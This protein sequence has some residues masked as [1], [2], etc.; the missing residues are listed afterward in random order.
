MK[1]EKIIS[2]LLAAALSALLLVFLS[3]C[4]L[5]NAP[6]E[7][8]DDGVCVT[9]IDVGQGD[10][11]F[12]QLP[13]S[14]CMLIDTGIRDE[15]DTVID[16]IEARGYEKIDYLVGTHP[17]ADHIGAMRDVI[18]AFEIGKIYMPKVSAD[19]ATFEKTLKLIDEKG[20]G[21]TTAKA[22]VN[23]LNEENLNIDILA[24]NSSEYEELNNYSAV[25]KL[26]Y[27]DTKFLFMG[28]AQKESESEITADV[29]ADF[30]K[31][32][33]HGSKTS[34]SEEFVRRVGAKYAAVSVAEENDYNLPVD[35]ILERWRDSGAEV[36]MTK[37]M[38]NIEAYSDGAN[39]TINGDSSE[40][41]GESRIDS[42]DEGEAEKWVLNTGT[43]RIH[44][45]DCPLARGISD[46][47]RKYSS[48]SIAELE[49][50]GYKPCGSCEPKE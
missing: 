39:I 3:S 14:R 2:K 16:Y 40:G 7:P 11:I 6:A 46:K 29:S 4:S 45:P 12:I 48:E 27:G 18:K 23:I 19:T 24:P 21:I 44:T 13:K 41:S 17:H 35:W 32:G 26:T 22:G 38:G 34:S 30:V 10:S 28:D 33:H 36:L 31:V 20:L 49:K 15:A 9:V 42:A 47:N 37:D 25:I 1:R 43:K 8:L 5:K 50:R